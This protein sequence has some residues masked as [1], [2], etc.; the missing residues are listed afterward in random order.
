MV[1]SASAALEAIRWAIQKICSVV[2]GVKGDYD[3]AKHVVVPSL[4]VVKIDRGNFI[5][6][7]I[8]PS[9]KNQHGRFPVTA[10]ALSGTWLFAGEAS[11]LSIYDRHT[12]ALI[13]TQH[14]FNE[15]SIHGLSL[16]GSS[17]P[18]ILLWG[19]SHVAILRVVVGSTENE[20]LSLDW[21]V[22]PIACPDWILDGQ[23]SPKDGIV[24]WE[25]D[26]RVLL[27]AGTIFGQV[28][29]WTGDLNASGTTIQVHKIF[30]GHEGSPFG[31]SFSEGAVLSDTG[32]PLRLLAS[33]SDDRTVRIWDVSELDGHKNQTSTQGQASAVESNTGFLNLSADEPGTSDGLVAHAMG[34]L[35]RIWGVQFL[36]SEHT[37]H[38]LVTF[39]EDA[40]CQFWTLVNLSKEAT[41]VWHGELENIGQQERH[42]GK[43]I[44][45]HAI[46]S[47]AEGPD[48]VATGGGDGSIVLHDAAIASRDGLAVQSKLSVSKEDCSKKDNIRSYSFLNSGE[49]LMALNSGTIWTIK[50]PSVIHMAESVD[51]RALVRRQICREPDLTGFSMMASVPLLS[52]AFLAGK[53]GSLFYYTHDSGLLKVLDGKRKAAGVLARS[54]PPSSDSTGSAICLLT[55]LGDK[56]AEVV[57]IVSTTP[58]KTAHSALNLPENEHV[59]SFNVISRNGD[60][61]MILAVGFR[62]GNLALYR[63]TLATDHATSS[64]PFPLLLQLLHEDA[65]TDILPT[66]L[67][68]GI[69]LTLA[70]RS[71][72]T[73]IHLLEPSSHTLTTLH[74]LATPLTEAALL[75]S[76]PNSESTLAG[77]HRK[78]FHLLP[79]SSPSTTSIPCGGSNRSWAF[80]PAPSDPSPTTTQ[81][82]TQNQDTTSGILAWTSASRTL[83]QSIP[84]PTALRIHPGSHGREIRAVASS[85]PLP[86]I[87]RLIATGAEDTD[88]KLSVFSPGASRAGPSGREMRCLRTLRKH[89]TGVQDLKW[90]A[91]G[92]YLVSAGGR[93]EVF[94]WRVR[95]LPKEMGEVGVVCASVCPFVSEEGDL[96]VLGVDVGTFSSQGCGEEGGGEGDVEGVDRADEGGCRLRVAMVRSDS[97]VGVYWYESVGGE[98]RWERAWEGSYLTCCLTNVIQ[99]PGRS[100]GFLTTATDGHAALFQLGVSDKEVQGSVSTIGWTERFKTHQS[101]V[102]AAALLPWTH[103][104]YLLFTGGDDNAFSI[105][106][107]K[108]GGSS[109]ST[110]TIP[111]AHAAA[112]TALEVISASEDVGKIRV[113]TA[114][115]DQR[116][117]LWEVSVDVSQTEVEG[118]EVKRLEDRYTPVA[119]VA[120]IDVWREGHETVTMI[121]GVGWDVWRFDT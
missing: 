56:A 92:R 15:T 74:H 30:S 73:S 4:D 102:H 27:A 55:R 41:G 89:N 3:K 8:S 18:Y 31:L 76:C 75:I 107:L 61:A 103:G 115:L 1:H 110:L 53:S 81:Q 29:V 42:S 101:A 6:H 65:I 105:S 63:T 117:K 16:R 12:G 38:N 48:L 108:D 13:H 104:T 36:S 7:L 119:D 26:D 34:H 21:V 84:S 78:S 95:V 54:T 116:I 50:L 67:S 9:M 66:P 59:S 112:L 14:V 93:E 39:G 68:S 106:L 32:S 79:P 83:L 64:T 10:L 46:F 82:P 43:H 72:S 47:N 37:G 17:F 111:R 35:S 49:M 100:G 62:S 98:G 71:G 40:T 80:L 57:Q 51:S 118:V 60:G 97:S 28:V 58:M 22:R 69:Y 121:C 44:W 20:R 70:S 25:S 2:V 113:V 11:A 86:R 5:C 109:T 88:I 120:C 91:D 33:C 96:R 52:A 23:F 24:C 114:G 45:S 77:F 19:G 99:V 87:G 85:P 94:V 90:S